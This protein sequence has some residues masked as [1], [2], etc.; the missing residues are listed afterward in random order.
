MLEQRASHSC[1]RL[2]QDCAARA[3]VNLQWTKL[4]VR[5]LRRVHAG[6]S[7]VVATHAQAAPDR[8]ALSCSEYR[9]GQSNTYVCGLGRVH[10]EVAGV[11]LRSGCKTVLH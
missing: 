8:A 5:G 3:A 9:S 10:A 2:H 4:R 1:S 11:V 6:N 7:S